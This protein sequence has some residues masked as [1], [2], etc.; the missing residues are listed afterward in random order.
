MFRNS[1]PPIDMYGPEELGIHVDARQVCDLN[2]KS[3][4]EDFLFAGLD[5]KMKPDFL[6]MATSLHGKVAY[7]QNSIDTTAVRLLA[8][9]HDYLVDSAKN[10]FSF[11]SGDYQELASTLP[12]VSLKT[13][14][15]P[16]YKQAMD[17]SARDD[18]TKK[19]PECD[20]LKYK[21]EH[22]NDLIY[23]EV[24]LPHIDAVLKSLLEIVDKSGT[25]D[26]DLTKIFDETMSS[27][28]DILVRAEL[29]QMS[30]ALECIYKSIWAPNV[31]QNFKGC[32][33][34]C[35]REYE[36]VQPLNP[37]HAVMRCWV[38]KSLEGIPSQWQ[39]I[40][41]SCLFKKF[42]PKS[43]FCFGVAGKQLAFL[44]AGTSDRIHFMS[45]SMWANVKPKKAPKGSMEVN[46][47]LIR[48]HVELGPVTP[49]DDSES[50]L[51]DFMTAPDIDVYTDVDEC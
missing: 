9:L 8:D 43:Q 46:P 5:F 31:K 4:A 33:E 26:A 21:K 40:K 34:K 35:F 15:E 49:A 28:H 23:F 39:L 7:H 19:G 37:D 38:Q 22:I 47:D 42:H 45:P 3:L 20:M 17:F 2:G 10:G 25:Y 41:A 51:G 30:R 50:E 36:L 32:T 14:K 18:Q 24:V 48:D 1:P 13:L 44:K 6:G 27:A 12:D 29:E 16:S 11:S